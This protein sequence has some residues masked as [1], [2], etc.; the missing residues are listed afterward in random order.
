MC[1]RNRHSFELQLDRIEINDSSYY[2]EGLYDVSLLRI[3]KFNQTTFVLNAE[4][5]IFVDIDEKLKASFIITDLTTINTT[6]L[7]L[8]LIENP[9]V[10]ILKQNTRKS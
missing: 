8:N 10:I 3:N 2:V 5:E 4:F 1:L 6:P 9:F 7:Q